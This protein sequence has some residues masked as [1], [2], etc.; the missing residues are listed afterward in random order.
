MII[1]KFEKK[2]ALEKLLLLTFEEI[3]LKS[4]CAA[5]APD[6]DNYCNKHHLSANSA[7]CFESMT[8]N[9]IDVYFT[10]IQKFDSC[11]HAPQDY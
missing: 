4:C 6:L 10:Q 2:T 9:N 7:T 1:I 11:L 5:L 3:P 8:K